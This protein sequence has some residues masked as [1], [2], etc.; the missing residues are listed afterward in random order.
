MMPTHRAISSC[1]AAACTRTSF[2]TQM[3]HK[4]VRHVACNMATAGTA[5]SVLLD[6]IQAEPAY[7]TQLQDLPTFGTLLGC[8]MEL[9]DVVNEYAALE[10]ARTQVSDEKGVF[11]RHTTAEPFKSAAIRVQTLSGLSPIDW[12]HHTFAVAP[13]YC[14][15]KSSVFTAPDC[16]TPH[17]ELEMGTRGDGSSVL[18]Y[19]NMDPRLSLVCHPHYLDHFYCTAPPGAASSWMELEH[20]VQQ[21]PGF[22]RFTSPSLHVRACSASAI[23]FNVQADEEGIKAVKGVVS[24]AVRIWLAW[25]KAGGSNSATDADVVKAAAGQTA[26]LDQQQLLREL[27]LRDEAWRGFPRREAAAAV[28]RSAFGDAAMEDY[29]DSMAGAARVRLP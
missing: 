23:L 13:S 26:G 2:V 3:R 15:S 25:L 28:L 19:M 17:L 10:R 22:E 4:P 29:W 21:L 12:A 7:A 14:Y 20:R 11:I 16:L 6:S 1:N 18:L 24:D 9:H 5:S 8:H 27:A